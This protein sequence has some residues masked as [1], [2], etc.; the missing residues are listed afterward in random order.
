MIV[1]TLKAGIDI[2]RP[3]TVDT[4][5]PSRSPAGAP[6]SGNTMT[7][8]KSIDKHIA[9]LQGDDDGVLPKEILK[10]G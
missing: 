9:S 1:D 2:A 8:T 4:L 3:P 10:N 6:S 5:T 7:K